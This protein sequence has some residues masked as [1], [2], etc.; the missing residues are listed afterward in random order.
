MGI[1]DLQVFR[2]EIAPCDH[3]VQ[4]YENG[5]IF[6]DSLE[7]FIGSGFIAGDSIIIIATKEHLTALE[8]RIKKQGFNLDSLSLTNRYIGLDA[9]DT[10]S[11]FMVN[12]CPTRAAIL[13]PLSL[14]LISHKTTGAYWQTSFFFNQF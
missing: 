14:T 8:V 9:E 5:K 7:G 10:L 1:I 2:G 3:V 4:I 12:G 6:L 11:K 13:L